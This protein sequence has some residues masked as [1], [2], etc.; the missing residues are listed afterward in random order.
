MNE[1][2]A[3]R[4]F[5]ISLILAILLSGG[6]TFWQVYSSQQHWCQALTTIT[7]HPVPEPADPNANPSRKQAYILYTEFRDLRREFGCG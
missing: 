4:V 7:E 6:F 5:G 3:F 2:R 1:Y